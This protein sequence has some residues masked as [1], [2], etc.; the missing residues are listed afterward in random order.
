[1]TRPDTTELPFANDSHFN[2]LLDRMEVNEIV[3]LFTCIIFEESVLLVADETDLLFPIAQALH[4]LIYPFEVPN[5]CPHLMNDGGEGDR[6]SIQTVCL[7]FSSYIMGI[8]SKD[9]KLAFEI[10]QEKEENND[11]PIVVQISK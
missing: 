7:P 6:N 5:F 8:S 10:I 1:M 9:G 4:Q 2:T 11:A 3:D